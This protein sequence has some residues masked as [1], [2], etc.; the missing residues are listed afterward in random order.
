MDLLKKGLEMEKAAKYL[1]GALD[2]WGTFEVDF[3]GFG[4]EE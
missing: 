4:V 2:D 3:S 1:G